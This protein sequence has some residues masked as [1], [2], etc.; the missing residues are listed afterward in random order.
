MSGGEFVTRGQFMG[1]EFSF[2]T[3]LDIDPNKPNMYD[4][5]FQIMENKPCEIVSPYMGDI[6]NA[7]VNIEKTH[8][9]ASPGSLK[10]DIKI[11]EIV[12]PKTSV[13]GDAVLEYPSTTTL[14][15]NAINIRTVQKGDTEKDKDEEEK[16]QII[17]DGLAKDKN[18]EE[19]H[20]V[21]GN[22]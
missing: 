3:T 16:A 6:F 22:E 9:K 20:S 13:V 2:T 17:Y 10:L 18:G 7:E 11:K 1:R 14:S 4:K 8:P 5:I 15:E 19:Y 12:T 21:Y